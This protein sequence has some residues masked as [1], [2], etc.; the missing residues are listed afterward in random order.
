MAVVDHKSEKN[1]NRS[2]LP[3]LNSDNDLIVAL[4]WKRLSEI[5]EGRLEPRILERI[6]LDDN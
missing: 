5:L 3:S 4:D 2:S 6:E 1:G